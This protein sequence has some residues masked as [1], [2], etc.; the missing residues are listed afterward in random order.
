LWQVVWAKGKNEL[1]LAK[2]L[3]SQ[4]TWCTTSCQVM[5]ASIW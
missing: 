2:P 5:K 3:D 1:R 4:A